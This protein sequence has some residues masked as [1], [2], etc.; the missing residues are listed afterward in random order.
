MLHPGEFAPVQFVK[1]VNLVISIVPTHFMFKWYLRDLI[2]ILIEISLEKE[3]TQIDSLRK[4]RCISSSCALGHPH[5]DQSLAVVNGHNNP[6]IRSRPCRVALP[7]KAA[8][9]IPTNFSSQITTGHM[10]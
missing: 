5:L 3:R 8:V 9:T 2:L 4:G 7:I 10:I 6:W 1:K